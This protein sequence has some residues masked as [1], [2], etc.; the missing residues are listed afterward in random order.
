VADSDRGTDLK[1]AVITAPKYLTTV[2]KINKQN[3]KK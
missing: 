3:T 2:T 1:G